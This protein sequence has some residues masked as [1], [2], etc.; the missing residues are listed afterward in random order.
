MGSLTLSLENS[1]YEIF[2]ITYFA[3]DFQN[4]SSASWVIN[5]DR[6]FD[7]TNAKLNFS[8]FPG[9]PASASFNNINVSFLQ[10]T[11]P[12]SAPSSILLLSLSIL[13]LSLRTRRKSV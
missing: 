10:N 4:L 3:E 11:I 12:V 2:N 5:D 8:L 1:L 13:G 9:S 6:F 7:L